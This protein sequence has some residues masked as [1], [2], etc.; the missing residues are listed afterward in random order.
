VIGLAPALLSMAGQARGEELLVAAAVSLR[1]PLLEIARAWREEEAGRELHFSFGASSALG[2]QIRAGAP[3]DVFLSA[4]ERIVEDLQARGLVAPRSSFV[5]ARN[6]LVVIQQRSLELEISAAEDLFA[7]KVRRIAMPGPAV[8]VG[9]YAREWLER[10]GLLDALEGRLVI[11]DHARAT[12]VAVDLG[13]AD[14][15]IVYATDA[16]MARSASIAFEI[17]EEQ[18]PQIRYAAAPTSGARPSAG[19]FLEFL[20]SRTARVALQRQGFTVEGSEQP[21]SGG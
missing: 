13:H 6:R 21:G 18:Q 14:L 5:L 16:R 10:V 2:A 17:P 7:P 1:E 12:L 8:P 11:T 4:D 19:D 20:R 3:I 9:R 15:A